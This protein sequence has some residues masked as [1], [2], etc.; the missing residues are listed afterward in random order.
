MLLIVYRLSWQG[1]T[2]I[3]PVVMTIGGSL[4]VFLGYSAHLRRQRHNCPQLS[5]AAGGV[6]QYFSAYPL[7]A[8]HAAGAVCFDWA[9]CVPNARITVRDVMAEPGIFLFISSLFMLII[10]SYQRWMDRQLHDVRK[11]LDDSN[12]RLSR[13]LASLDDLMFVVD[14]N[15]VFVDYHHPLNFAKLFI[16]PAVYR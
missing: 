1:H 4:S 13:T 9:V 11:A 5:G 14:K 12:E 7:R 6:R 2:T 16:P 8:G 15:R 3:A 10:T